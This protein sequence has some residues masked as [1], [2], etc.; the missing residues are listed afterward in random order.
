M[1]RLI[2]NRCVVL[3]LCFSWL[4]MRSRFEFIV[5]GILFASL[6][7]SASIAAKFGLRSVEPMVL[8]SIRFLV[9]G[10][11]LLAYAYGVEKQSL[12]D[13]TAWKQ[14]II[15]SLLNTSLY[16]GFFIVALTQ[17]AAGIGSLATA[18]NPLFIGVLSSL[19]LGRNLRGREWL[20]LALGLVGVGVASFPL[21]QQAGTTLT[22]LLLL[23]LSMLS[24]SAGALYYRRV[25]W[26]LSR[27]AINGWQVLLGGLTIAPLAF[28]LHQSP[29]RFDTTW[30]ASLA[31]L[32]FPV[33]IVS[34][35]LW[36]RLLRTDAVKASFFLLLCPVFGF[37]YA[38]WL[39]DEPFTLYTFGGTVLVLAGLYGG[40][41][42]VKQK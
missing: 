16:L 22:G 20:S 5:T 1:Y 23:G 35:Q 13:R 39:L 8:F 37:A 29:N 26:S 15:F 21:L 31:W 4:H 9:A 41:Q 3:S 12:P 19:W 6:W 11:L 28:L 40:Q 36:L 32:V 10:L 34:V 2:R 33:S 7:A 42:P 24:Y 18:T 27:S 14:L 17:V 38:T 25:A 30:W